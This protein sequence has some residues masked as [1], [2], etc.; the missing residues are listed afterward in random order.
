MRLDVSDPPP[1]EDDFSLHF[2]A[3]DRSE[4]DIL[5]LLNVLEAPAEVINRLIAVRRLQR[6]LAVTPPEAPPDAF[7]TGQAS[8]LRRRIARF[9]ET[10]CDDSP[11]RVV[12]GNTK[13]RRKALSEASLAT[14][15]LDDRLFRLIQ[16]AHGSEA[17]AA[18][19]FLSEPLYQLTTYYEPCNYI[20]WGYV[21]DEYGQDPYQP[22]LDLW[23]EGAQLGH[24]DAGYFV[25][26]EE[27]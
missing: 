17:Y 15:P 12:H 14:E 21:V 16:A 27:R 13:A 24:D 20:L 22:A 18:A 9:L 19:Y 8:V 23:K 3:W 7:L 6:K 11:I 26:V 25:F 5:R 4:S 2:E 10:E 1:Y